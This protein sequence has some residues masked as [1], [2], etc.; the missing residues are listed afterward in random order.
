M[1]APAHLPLVFARISWHTSH[2][3]FG[4]CLGELLLMHA[5]FQDGGGGGGGEMPRTGFVIFFYSRNLA[6]NARI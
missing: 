4:D 6:I 2:I 3:H 1:H 5:P